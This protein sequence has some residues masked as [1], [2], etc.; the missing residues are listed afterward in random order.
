MYLQVPVGT[1][2]AME[3]TENKENSGLSANH[4]EDKALDP[5]EKCERTFVTFSDESTYRKSF[6]KTK[7]KAVQKNICPITR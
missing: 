6:R 5:S 4:S 3:V 7:P 2:A 1:A